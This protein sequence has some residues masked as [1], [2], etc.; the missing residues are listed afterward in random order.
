MEPWALVSALGR[1]KRELE[2]RSTYILADT[3]LTQ[4]LEQLQLAQ[5]PQ[6]EHG[7]LKGRDLFD[8]DL[9]PAGTVYCRTNDAIGTL[10]NDIEDLVLCAWGK[11]E[12]GVV[13]KLWNSEHRKS[14]QR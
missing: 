7:M 3:G 5:S 2:Q 1:L 9:A 13:F 11:D 4:E 10:A 12:S 8:G 14:Y 6:T